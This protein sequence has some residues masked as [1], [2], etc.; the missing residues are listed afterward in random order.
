MATSQPDY[1]ARPAEGQRIAAL[2]LGIAS[3][4]FFWVPFIGLLL[5]IIGAV[6]AGINMRQ[7]YTIIGLAA[8]ITSLI[9]VALGG[10][11]TFGVI[12][13]IVNART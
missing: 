7:S 11:T 4:V 2:V 5:G 3:V 10:L 12:Y 1:A 9:G 6:L 8:L 13:A